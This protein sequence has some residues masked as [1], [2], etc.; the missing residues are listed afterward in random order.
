[1][2]SLK[3]MLCGTVLA[4]A[5]LGLPLLANADPV[6]MKLADRLPAEHFIVKNGLDP[7]IAA[8]SGELTIQT[9]HGQQLGKGSEG[10]NMLKSGIAQI[11]EMS[12]GLIGQEMQ[13]SSVTELPLA[14]TACQ[15]QLA[16]AALQAPGGAL[17]KAESTPNGA[18]L[19]ISMTVAPYY[20]FSTKELSGPADL[21][22]LKI[23]TQGPTLDKV[24]VALGATPTRVAASEIH[25]A[26][27]RGTVDGVVFPPLSV[28]NY[29]IGS[30]IKT[31]LGGSSFGQS[32]LGYFVN[33]EVFEALPA[34]TQAKMLAAGKDA[35]M[36]LCTYMQ[37]QEKVALEKLTSEGAKVVIVS[38]ADAALMQEKLAP[39]AAQWAA[40]MD[41]KGQPGSAV[42]AEYQAALEAAKAK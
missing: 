23:A 29:D 27:T 35:A 18:T 22:G 21:E 10:L 6:E 8:M 26:I 1:M 19:V 13:L 37:D 12:P 9:Y 41:S 2:L 31:V 40:D 28:L 17:D 39:L 30:Y 11:V 36:Q 34:E 14:A 25:D 42:L 4:G 20:L 32:A 16:Y 24:L 33:R 5:V 7:W 3:S 38:G 15:G